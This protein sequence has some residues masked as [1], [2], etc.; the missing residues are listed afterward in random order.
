MVGKGGEPPTTINRRVLMARASR[1]VAIDA[2]EPRLCLAAGNFAGGY[3]IGASTINNVVTD[4][5]GNVYVSGLFRETADFN[6]SSKK[7]YALT[8]ASPG[9]ADGFVAKYTPD[10]GL[11]W[12]RRFREVQTAGAPAMA[13]DPRSGDVLGGGRFGGTIDFGKDATRKPDP[14]SPLTLTS[15]GP[16]YNGYFARLNATSGATRSVVPIVG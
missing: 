12:V 2:L 4:R 16:G 14:S 8:A 7:T 1:V 3:V 6:P 5:N 13:L 10:G 11:F 15:K 9:G